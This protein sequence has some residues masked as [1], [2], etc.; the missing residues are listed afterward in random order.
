[1]MLPEQ[2]LVAVGSTSDVLTDL[3]HALKKAQDEEQRALTDA[4]ETNKTSPPAA[5]P[6]G[7]FTVVNAF[8][9]CRCIGLSDTESAALLFG[10][11]TTMSREGLHKLLVRES[12]RLVRS[13]VQGL[14][15]EAD[16]FR[17]GEL[18]LSRLHQALVR[19]DVCLTTIRIAKGSVPPTA[20]A[21]EGISSTLT[22]RLV[23]LRAGGVL[24]ITVREELPPSPVAAPVVAAEGAATQPTVPPAPTVTE[25]TTEAI[26]SGAQMFMDPARGEVVYNGVPLCN[27]LTVEELNLAVQ[28]IQGCAFVA[29]TAASLLLPEEPSTALYEPLL[30]VLVAPSNVP[31]NAVSLFTV[32]SIHRWLLTGGA[33]KRLEAARDTAYVEPFLAKSRNNAEAQRRNFVPPSFFGRDPSKAPTPQVSVSQPQLAVP[34]A[35]AAAASE[36][37]TARTTATVAIREVHLPAEFQAPNTAV[38]YTIVSVVNTQ[39]TA[40]LPGVVVPAQPA[41]KGTTDRVWQFSK[42]RRFAALVVAEPNDEIYIEVC[43]DKLDANGA[44]EKTYCA[45][46]ATIPVANLK[47]GV[48]AVRQGTYYRRRGTSAAGDDDKNEGGC[49]CFGKTPSTRIRIDVDTFPKEYSKLNLFGQRMVLLERHAKLAH[50]FKNLLLQD[51]SRH[52]ARTLRKYIVAQGF[53]LIQTPLFL[54]VLSECWDSVHSRVTQEKKGPAAGSRTQDEILR[55]ELVSLIQRL[56]AATNIA[57]PKREAAEYRNATMDPRPSALTLASNGKDA[58]KPLFI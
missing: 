19:S 1:M 27:G 17:S 43:V 25:V 55:D 28:A 6:D 23:A 30:N 35:S 4:A 24:G 21:K 53:A 57:G 45:G 50:A 10:N 34:A 29:T 46:F 12:L 26:Q 44:P 38:K 51:D 15:H 31:S 47:S 39:T 7:H 56:N 13:K 52:A 18:S 40:M 33:S 2:L 20:A 37:N 5:I 9:A 32:N 16:R 14:F 3:L 11:T 8:V 54:D 41:A 49:L 48:Y 58:A 42:K 22:I 36:S